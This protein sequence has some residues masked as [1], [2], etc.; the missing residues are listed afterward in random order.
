MLGDRAS[1]R[2]DRGD[3]V[4]QPSQVFLIS[5][6]LPERKVPVSDVAAEIEQQSGLRKQS[7]EPE[8]DRIVAWEEEMS[9]MRVPG[10]RSVAVVTD[11][12]PGRRMGRSRRKVAVQAAEDALVTAG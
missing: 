12:L 3:I 6:I 5:Q 4:H 2:N 1:Q 9:L 11:L 8:Q 7:G 10:R